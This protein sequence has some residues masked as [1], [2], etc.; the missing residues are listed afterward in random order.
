MDFATGGPDGF[1]ESSFEIP[2]ANGRG[3]WYGSCTLQ[4]A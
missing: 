1:L 2:Q 4:K 3:I